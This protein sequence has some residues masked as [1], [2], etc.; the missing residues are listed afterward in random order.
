MPDRETR[1]ARYV[2]GK[3]VDCG[4]RDH[5]AGRTRCDEC[6]GVWARGGLLNNEGASA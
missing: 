4:E 6:H 1:A 3:C 2:T 5:S